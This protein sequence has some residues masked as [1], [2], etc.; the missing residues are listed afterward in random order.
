MRDYIS[1]T[2]KDD[3]N[4][5][6]NPKLIKPALTEIQDTPKFPNPISGDSLSSEKINEKIRKMQT[7]TSYEEQKSTNKQ[8]TSNSFRSK[9]LK[10]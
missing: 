2:N 1:P 4:L 3:K 6:R 7:L 10:Q 9:L 5:S 8:N